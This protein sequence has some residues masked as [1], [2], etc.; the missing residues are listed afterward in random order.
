MTIPNAVMTNNSSSVTGAMVCT[1]FISDTV[2]QSI[3][4]Q[5]VLYASYHTANVNRQYEEITK[6]R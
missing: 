3:R 4:D 6:D 2:A 1:A 5:I